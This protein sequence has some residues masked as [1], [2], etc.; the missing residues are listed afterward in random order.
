MTS[1]GLGLEGLGLGLE[2][3][4][5]GLGLEGPGLGLGLEGPGLG[6]GLEGPG[7]VNITGGVTAVVAATARLWGPVVLEEP[8]RPC[9][10]GPA[11]PIILLCLYMLADIGRSKTKIRWFFPWHFPWRHR[12]FFQR[13]KFCGAHDEL[14]R[15]LVKIDRNE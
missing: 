12:I 9:L 2:G 14:F 8:V 13:K 3:P 10:G 7:L 4:G 15:P 6:L 5:L 1:C 11:A